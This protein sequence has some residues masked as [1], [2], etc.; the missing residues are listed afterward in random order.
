[1]ATICVTGWNEGFNKIQ[2]GTLLRECCGFS[3]S[4]GKRH[5]DSILRDELVSIEVSPERCE[6]FVSTA[7]RLG[8]ICEVRDA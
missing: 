7:G 4:E 1:V 5:V 2:F 8:A 6:Y 3:L